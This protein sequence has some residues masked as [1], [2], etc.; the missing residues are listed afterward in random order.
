MSGCVAIADRVTMPCVGG[1]KQTPRTRLAGNILYRKS[2]PP[3]RPSTET[4]AESVSGARAGTCGSLEI[5]GNSVVLG[6]HG[7]C[8]EPYRFCDLEGGGVLGRFLVAAPGPSRAGAGA[9]APAAL[10]LTK[11]RGR[12]QFA[13]PPAG[14]QPAQAQGFSAAT[15]SCFPFSLL[16]PLFLD[17][18]SLLKRKNMVRAGFMEWILEYSSTRQVKWNQGPPL[19]EWAA[20]IRPLLDDPRGVGP[21]P[22]VLTSQP[23]GHPSPALFKLR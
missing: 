14:S 1:K 23:R 3:H 20:C 9:P 18:I 21:R 10:C 15:L 4:A 13:E 16:L 6:C 5:V 2:F 12:G 19:G 7:F 17:L 22:A 11:A 8:T